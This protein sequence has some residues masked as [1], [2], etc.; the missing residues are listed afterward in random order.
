MINPNDI[1]VIPHDTILPENFQY[2]FHRMKYLI[3]P[4]IVSSSFHPQGYNLMNT[5][6][7]PFKT[8]G[9]TLR[10]LLTPV[11]SVEV[12]EEKEDLFFRYVRVMNDKTGEFYHNRGATIYVNLKAMEGRFIF[13]FATCN[14]KDNFNTLISRNVCIN[15]MKGNQVFEVIN[16]DPDISILQNI[17]L[18]IGVYNDEYPLTDMTWQDILPELYGTFTPEMKKDLTTLRNLIRHKA[19]D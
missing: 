12:E 2:D 19:N 3:T 5:Q 7:A 15:R 18:A 6:L 17:F 4:S 10:N 9:E 8:I 16:Y 1:I 13:S 11:K 14:H